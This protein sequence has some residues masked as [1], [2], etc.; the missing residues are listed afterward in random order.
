[1]VESDIRVRCVVVSARC[2]IATL[3][4]FT[5]SR[6]ASL[7]AQ[8]FGGTPTPTLE[9]RETLPAARAARESD[10]DDLSNAA[11]YTRRLRL[12]SRVQDEGGDPRVVLL[13]PPRST[14]HALAE[15]ERNDGQRTIAHGLGVLA[16]GLGAGGIVTAV[17]ASIRSICVF[18]CDQDVPL[19]GLGVGMLG[20]AILLTVA[21]LSLLAD[22]HAWRDALLSRLGSLARGDLALVTW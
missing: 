6:A 7:E 3:I 4:A 2:A 13:M 1:M 11:Q 21:A 22:A 20:S 5:C 12:A 15:L 19:I 17:H 16:A 9:A 14:S 8:D 18:R 10:V